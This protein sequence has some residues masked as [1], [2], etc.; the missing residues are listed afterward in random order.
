MIKYKEL[1][2]KRLLEMYYLSGKS[3]NCFCSRAR[4]Q[5]NLKDA[6]EGEAEKC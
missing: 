4:S 2:D 6:P 3:L 5:M 1:E